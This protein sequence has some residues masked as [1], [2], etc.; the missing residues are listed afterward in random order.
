MAN[1]VTENGEINEDYGYAPSMVSELA[2]PTKDPAVDRM[3]NGT[4]NFRLS[5]T[6]DETRKRLTEWNERWQH[7]H[8]VL[9]KCPD[10]VE[11]LAPNVVLRAADSASNA[12]T[13]VSE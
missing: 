12:T 7:K 2:F 8:I 4:P 3:V 5:L 9:W 11:K 6:S 13:S 10:L 1:A